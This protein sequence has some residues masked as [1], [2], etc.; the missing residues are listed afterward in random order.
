[1]LEAIKKGGIQVAL[2][3]LFMGLGQLCQRQ[4]GKGLTY[5]FLHISALWFFLRYGA[6]MLRGFITLGERRANPTLNIEGDNSVVMLI[7]GLFA[8]IV[9]IGYLLL[10]AA[11]IKDAYNTQTLIAAGKKPLRFSAELKSLADK[12][13]YRSALFLPILGVCVFS[14]IPIVFMILVAFTDFGGNTVPPELVSW[15][16]M[17]SF[18]RIL[19]LQQF[20]PTFFMILNWNVIWAVCATAL[21]YFGGLGLALLLNKKCV[22]GKLIWRAFPILAFAIPGFI[23]LLAFK[24]MFSYGGPL[25][26]MIINAGYSPIG[27]LDLDAKWMARII[28]L[29]IN[30][31]LAIPSSMLLAA[32]ILSNMSKDFSEAAKI[33]GASAFQ[34]FRAIT[35]PFVLFAT[36]PVLISQFIMNFNNFGIFF[37]LRGG[38]YID[39]YFLASDTDLL[40]NWL[41]NLT[42]DNNYYSIGAAVS[43]V[44]FIITSIISLTVYVLSP[45]YR[46]EDQFK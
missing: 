23:N 3:A 31:W 18:F 34:I 8:I 28:G 45:S 9:L 30:A 1:M 37:F 25:N 14:V 13:F 35:L 32:G 16:G 36:V 12:N 6:V 15:T 27:F 24:F 11:N 40:I 2:S 43:V 39:G 38:L 26:Q 33:D 20:A 19:T 4:V 44:I 46:Q 42:I 41:Y 5:L 21:N 10:Y 17:D 22:K 29:L 7:M